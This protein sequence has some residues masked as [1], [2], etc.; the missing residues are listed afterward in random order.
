VILIAKIVSGT[1]FNLVWGFGDLVVSWRYCQLPATYKNISN[2]KTGRR[3]PK[4]IIS[5][6][7][8]YQS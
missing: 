7:L 1:G 8:P 3:R 6:P 4:I 5:L 2:F